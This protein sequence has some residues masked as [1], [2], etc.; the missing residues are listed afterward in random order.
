MTETVLSSIKT[1]IAELK[2]ARS[3]VPV[4][5][6]ELL[7]KAVCS[8][9]D[10][11]EKLSCTCGD[12]SDNLVSHSKDRPCSYYE[13]VA[14]LDSD[15]FPWSIEGRE[16]RTVSDTYRPLYLSPSVKEWRNFTKEEVNS[17][18]LPGSPTVFEFVCFVYKK[19]KEK[20]S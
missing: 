10:A 16:W 5:E 12:Y 2:K 17:W 8:L 18:D 15:G 1:A 13:P 3:W 6:L 11:K 4:Q 19:I 14:W 9:N 20:N 7:E